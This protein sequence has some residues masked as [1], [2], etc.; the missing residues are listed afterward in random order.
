[1]ISVLSDQPE[2]AI[3]KQFMTQ[4]MVNILSNAEQACVAAR[5]GRHIS[6][7]V[8][9]TDGSTRISISDDGTGI[10]AETLTKVF[11]PFFTTKEVGEETGLGL[12]VS[13]GIITQLGGE[14]WAESDG[15]SGSTFH[16]DVPR[17]AAEQSFGLEQTESPGEEL[18]DASELP[19]RGSKSDTHVL[20]VGDVLDLREA[21]VKLL[22]RKGHTTQQAADG[23][24][25]WSR[26]QEGSFDCILLD[27]R[28][29]GMSG[30]DLFRR[31]T[32][33]DPDSAAKV[34]FFTGDLTNAETRAFLESLDNR[35]LVKP[36]S[37][38]ELEE[39]IGLVTTA[40]PDRT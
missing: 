39:A 19:K 33:S 12:S 6:I 13:Y 40:G 17:E 20:V 27:L 4:V 21:V 30:Q 34:G 10:P 11:D 1:L 35:V 29:P 28:M 18:S 16:I 24:K 9:E 38:Q 15:S 37:V 36:V 7:S 25:A 14:L 8:R 26:I 32:V 23:E 22:E 5:N 3:D 31:I 2:I